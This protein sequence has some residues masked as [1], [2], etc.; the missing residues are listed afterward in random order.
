MEA[1]LASDPLQAISMRIEKL[2]ESGE[3][4]ASLLSTERP[5]LDW[6]QQMTWAL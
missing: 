2:V 3:L 4:A 6:M 5:D 1:K